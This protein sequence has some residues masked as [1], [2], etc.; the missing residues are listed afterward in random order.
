LRLFGQGEDQTAPD[1]LHLSLDGDGAAEEVDVVACEREDLPL[2]HAAT[3][4]DGRED[5]VAVR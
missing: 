4:T 1:D 3:R 2:P 5:A